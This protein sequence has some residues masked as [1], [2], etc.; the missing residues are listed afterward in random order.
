MINEYSTNELDFR[1]FVLNENRMFLGQEIGN[2]L[3]ALQEIQDEA[4]KIG[5]K[6]LVRFTDRIV[7]QTRSL[8]G[9]HWSDDDVKFLKG[10]QKVGVAL[11]KALD[12]SDNLEETISSCVGEIQNI[13]KKMNVPVNNLAV[14]PKEAGPLPET[15]PKN[16]M[17]PTEPDIS[18]ELASGFNL[19]PPQKPQAPLGEPPLP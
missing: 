3:T 8:L 13:L 4:K 18:P 1:S 16:I 15:S 12:E 5:T 7:C 19:N 9:G 11:A 2:I 10:M 14:T 6:N 17:G